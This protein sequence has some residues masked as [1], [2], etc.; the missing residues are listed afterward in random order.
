M[1][2]RLVLRLEDKWLGNFTLKVSKIYLYI[3]LQERN[4]CKLL[5]ILVPR[6]LNYKSGMSCHK[7]V[8]FEQFDDQPDSIKWSVTSQGFFTGCIRF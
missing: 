1:V 6:L 2:L 7:R 5:R 8:A 3:V 4:I